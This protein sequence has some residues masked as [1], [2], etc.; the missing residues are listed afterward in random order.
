VA[1][2]SW[3]AHASDGVWQLRP[4]PE[5]GRPDPTRTHPADGRATTIGAVLAQLGLKP[6]IRGTAGS[7]GS[8]PR[9]FAGIANPTAAAVPCQDGGG[10][11]RP[12]RAGCSPSARVT[13]PGGTEPLGLNAHVRSAILLAAATASAGCGGGSGGGGAGAVPVTVTLLSSGSYDGSWSGNPSGPIFSSSLYVGDWSGP[14]QGFRGFV[15]FDLSALPPGVTV[16]DATL[17]LNAF[18][19]NVTSSATLGD[20]FI[21]H[22]VYGLVLEPGAYSRSGPADAIATLSP[23]LALGPHSIPVTSAVVNDFGVRPQSQFRLRFGVETNNDASLD[24]INFHSSTTA[25]AVS[26]RPMLVV[27]YQP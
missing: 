16:L 27:T 2:R 9:S 11:L 19:T 21:D 4:L 6:E 15:S 7:C 25:Q 12:A 3:Q 24:R 20:L 14:A 13:A 23:P 8:S 10:G 26:E 1:H 22:V 18:F 17:V 5:P